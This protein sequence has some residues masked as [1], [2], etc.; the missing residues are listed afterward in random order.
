[1]ELVC[2]SLLIFSAIMAIFI[3]SF[4]YIYTK[5]VRY[6]SAGLW[7]LVSILTLAGTLASSV[8]VTT[9]LAVCVALLYIVLPV[10]ILWAVIG[11]ALCILAHGISHMQIFD[12]PH[13]EGPEH[14]I[15]VSTH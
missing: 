12:N 4:N 14:A 11:G 13:H 15:V 8:T 5:T 10:P 9:A 3:S 1:M 2:A 6:V 7:T